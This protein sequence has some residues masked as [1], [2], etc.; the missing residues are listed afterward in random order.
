MG[1]LFGHNNRYDEIL[2]ELEDGEEWEDMDA[3]DTVELPEEFEADYAEDMEVEVLG[4]F[5]QEFDDYFQESL[6]RH[7]KEQEPQQALAQEI[8]AESEIEARQEIDPEPETEQEYSK[9]DDFEVEM[10]DIDGYEDGERDEEDEEEYAGEEY[11]AEDAEDGLFGV[12]S[13]KMIQ[14]ALA[15]FCVCLAGVFGVSMYLGAKERERQVASNYEAIGGNMG[16]L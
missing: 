8:E 13:F 10:F 9:A 5:T 1:K 16:N 14:V 2:R 3:E 11:D 12:V 15:V 4:E 7:F 6:S